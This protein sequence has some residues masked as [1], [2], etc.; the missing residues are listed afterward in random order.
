MT[1]SNTA[2]WK[3]YI[4]N[5]LQH[6]WPAAIVVRCY[7]NGQGAVGGHEEDEAEEEVPEDVHEEVRH[8]EQDINVA[9]GQDTEAQAQGVADEGEVLQSIVQQ[10]HNEDMEA[11]EI[12][13]HE[14]SADE[15]FYV[16][17]EWTNP[18]FGN[19]MVHDPREQEC[20]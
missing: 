8:V 10:M 1:I 4:D 19:P 12:D 16:P 9:A 17:S 18:G 7:L 2:D 14:N 15:D 20:E 3:V 11:T 13:E 5:A 6:G